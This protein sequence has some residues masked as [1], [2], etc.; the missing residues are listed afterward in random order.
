M[1]MNRGF[2]IR[3]SPKESC[4]K[5]ALPGAQRRERLLRAAQFSPPLS[6][7]SGLPCSRS[8]SHGRVPQSGALLARHRVAEP[9]GPC[10]PE[11]RST[12]SWSWKLLTLGCLCEVL[13]PTGVWQSFLGKPKV[14]EHVVKANDEGLKTANPAQANPTIAAPSQGISAAWLRGSAFGF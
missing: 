7:L 14:C 10:P 4:R 5:Q 3:G 9:R 2:P 8:S 1:L 13:R 6:G 12:L 11:A